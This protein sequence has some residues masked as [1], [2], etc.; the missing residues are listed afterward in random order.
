MQTGLME[1]ATINIGVPGIARRDVDLRSSDFTFFGEKLDDPVGTLRTIEGR[2]C[3]TFNHLN[4]VNAAQVQRVEI[5]SA[6]LDPVDQ[7]DR[8]CSSLHGIDTSQYD[9]HRVTGVTAD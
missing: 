6:H 3:S 1:I 7:N 4:P 9:I 8:Q 5:S 2:G